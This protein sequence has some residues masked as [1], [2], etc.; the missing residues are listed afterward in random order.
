MG[1]E[2]GT[3]AEIVSTHQKY[4]INH[5]NHVEPLIGDNI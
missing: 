3:A 5:F 1:E 4:I 2:Y